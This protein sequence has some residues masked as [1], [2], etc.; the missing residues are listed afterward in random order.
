M[1]IDKQRVLDEITTNKG[2]LYKSKPNADGL[3]QYVWRMCEFH[4]GRNT[5]M[6][7]MASYWLQAYLDQ[8]GIQASV[9]GVLD[10]Q[11]HAILEEINGVVNWCLGELDLSQSGAAKEWRKVL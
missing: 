1:E 10:D 3:C 4:S 7:V 9:S 6:P 2:T 8:K 11:G 5:C